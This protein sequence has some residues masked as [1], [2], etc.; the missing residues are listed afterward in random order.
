MIYNVPNF[1]IICAKAEGI[2][3]AATAFTPEHLTVDAIDY[4]AY[5]VLQ[6]TI[7]SAENEPITPGEFKLC[8]NQGH[9]GVSTR[10]GAQEADAICKVK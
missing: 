9:T 10:P 6:R 7:V 1:L 8:T 5:L 3:V 2:W 4:C